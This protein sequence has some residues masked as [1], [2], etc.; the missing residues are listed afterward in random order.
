VATPT[1]LRKRKPRA[2]RPRPSGPEVRLRLQNK[3]LLRWLDSWLAMPDDQGEAWWNEFEA[4]LQS[5]PAAFRP[6]QAG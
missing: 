3:K 6:I 5:H 2:R 1:I 4:D